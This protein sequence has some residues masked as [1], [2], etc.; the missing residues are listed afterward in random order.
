MGVKIPN[1]SVL[2]ISS[3]LSNPVTVTAISNGT[4]PVVTANG[5]TYSNGDVVA[6][7]NGWAGVTDKAYK[8][9]SVV[10]GVSFRLVGADTTSTTEFP[11]L[12]SGGT[13]QKVL[14][15]VDIPNILSIDFSGG[16]QQYHTITYLKE[17]Q[18]KEVP[19]IK[20]PSTMEL[21][22]AEDLKLPCYPVLTLADKLGTP[23]VQRL[24]NR[25]TGDVVLYLSVVSLS[26]HPRITRNEVVSRDISFSLRGTI[27]RYAG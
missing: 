24:T 4:N 23:Y 22:V 13:V 5:H 20:S 15:W 6:L 18:S 9:T 19:T 1:G 25:I 27:T 14:G 17:K 12:S 3:S 7:F 26:P 11:P 16:G 21:Q 2:E 8:I 10:A